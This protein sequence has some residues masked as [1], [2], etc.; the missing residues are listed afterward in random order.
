MSWIIIC[1]CILDERNKN[2]TSSPTPEGIGSTYST[3]PELAIPK[4]EL[5]PSEVLHHA[6]SR[7]MKTGQRGALQKFFIQIASNKWHT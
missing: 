4:R 2:K 7:I 6:P 5:P 3:M 1:A